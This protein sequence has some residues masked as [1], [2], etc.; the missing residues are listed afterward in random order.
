MV[1]W[2]LG[3]FVL[4]GNAFFGLNLSVRADYDLPSYDEGVNRMSRRDF[5]GAILSFNTAVGSNNRNA[6]AYF[7]RGQ[8]FYYLQS[9]KM[10]ID[11]FS[12]AI[13][14][15]PNNSEYFLWRGATNCKAGDDPRS[16]MDYEEALRLDPALLKAASGAAPE[17]Q[18]DGL[19]SPMFAGKENKASSAKAVQNE[20]SIHNYMEAVKIVSTGAFPVFVKGTVFSGIVRPEFPA[21]KDAA[22]L[23]PDGLDALL[24]NP[25]AAFESSRQQLER[26]PTDP[27]SHFRRAL[28]LQ[29][30]GKMQRSIDD[31]SDAISQ[32]PNNLQYLL[33][34]AYLQH[35]NH[36]EAAAKAD[37]EKAQAV[38]SSLP[39]VIKFP[40]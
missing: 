24:A 1:K 33:A 34:R 19:K 29:A 9:Y 30:Q 14:C 5:D 18:E 17:K 15:D 22:Y 25:K 32:Q 26:T 10:A 3:A 11:D 38:D 28:A 12:S 7:K 4:L 13:S 31:L 40:D 23:R 6:R 8:C 20:Q 21:D 2:K 39:K 35:S 27:V 37:I 16:I 36:N